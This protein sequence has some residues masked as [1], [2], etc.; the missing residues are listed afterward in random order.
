M[1]STHTIIARPATTAPTTTTART[2]APP[3]RIQN[4]ATASLAVAY[5]LIPAPTIS[6]IEFTTS[7]NAKWRITATKAPILNADQMDKLTESGRIQVP[8]PEM[9]FGNNRVCLQKFDEEKYN[10]DTTIAVDKDSLVVVDA[11]DALGAV[12]FGNFAVMEDVKVSY[13]K[14]WTEKSE[15]LHGKIKKIAKPYD[16]TYTPKGYHTTFGGGVRASAD[17]SDS[18]S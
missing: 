18:A 7:T 16:W 14:E 11:V 9:F 10:A 13:S 3:T 2:M 6:G 17:N 12:A 1:I 4:T 8:F 5:T 15:R